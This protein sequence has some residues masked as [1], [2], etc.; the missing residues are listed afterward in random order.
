MPS[1]RHSKRLREKTRVDQV[2]TQDPGTFSGRIG[3]K[4]QN[5]SA[6]SVYSALQAQPTL[7][8]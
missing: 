8:A 2:Q 6:G 5:I 1:N 4:T 7:G 3:Q